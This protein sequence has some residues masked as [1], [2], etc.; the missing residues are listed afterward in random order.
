MGKK[1]RKPAT[2]R[3]MGSRYKITF[4]PLDG[5]CGET[6]LT[7]RLIHINSTMSVP[8][9]K[10]TLL[11]EILHTCLEDCPDL[12]EGAEARGDL[13]EENIV[14]WLSP[15]LFQVLRDNVGVRRFVCEEDT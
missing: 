15:R 8:Q 9:Q 6:N 7:D 3:V 13:L 1:A 2:V 5:L 11:H 12:F 10:E 4:T 14:Q